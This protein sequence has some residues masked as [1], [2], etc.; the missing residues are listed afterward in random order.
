MGIIKSFFSNAKK[1]K[2]R[3]GRVF[4]RLMNKGHMPISKW[5]LSHIPK[6]RYKKILDMGCGGGYN[7]SK[8]LDLYPDAF[9]SGADYSNESL[10]VSAKLNIRALKDGRLSLI[11]ADVSDLP[12]KDGSFDLITAFETVYFWPGPLESFQEIYRVM[13]DDGVFVLVNEYNEKDN[14]SEVFMKII[15][16][17][18]MYKKDK[19]VYYL[20]KAGFEKIR[21]Y[22]KG[23]FIVLISEKVA[24]YDEV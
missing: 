7:I 22:T 10:E 1:P 3:M 5:G 19:L 11:K 12:Y 6:R 18:N 9:I 8:L 16:G 24:R 13:E 17:M 21:A 15:D 4:L 14:V 23:K 20:K 2:G